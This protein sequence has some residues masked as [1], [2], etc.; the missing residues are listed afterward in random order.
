V[1]SAQRVPTGARRAVR[2]VGCTGSRNG[3]TD[4]QRNAVRRV[5]PRLFVP[6]SVL[7][8]GDCVGS[9][10]EIAAVGRECGFALYSHPPSDPRLRA[11]VA[12]D[13]A[14]PELPYLERN[15]VI[16]RSIEVLVACPDGF[17][18]RDRSGTWATVRYAAEML[19]PVVVVWPD[20]TV[21]CK[22]PKAC[23]R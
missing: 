9:D 14:A 22:V 12:S 6:A 21:T 11:F 2:R 5:L 23:A 19:V 20:G 10:E 13:F 18:E 17:T 8:H 16:V 1:G 3:V 7:H 4:W 15:R